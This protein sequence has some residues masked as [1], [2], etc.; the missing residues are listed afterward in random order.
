M[1]RRHRQRVACAR[2]CVACAVG[3]ACDVVGGRRFVGVGV[4]AVHARALGGRFLGLLARGL[5]APRPRTRRL[6]AR[7]G[8][9][10][11]RGQHDLAVLVFSVGLAAAVE[12]VAGRA[13]TLAPAVADVRMAA[14]AIRD[15]YA[16]RDAREHLDGVPPWTASLLGSGVPF[17]GWTRDESRSRWVSPVQSGGE[18]GAWDSRI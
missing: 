7:C 18:A 1:P 15:A 10:C 6:A 2:A 13:Q 11:Q 14:D 17:W 8:E 5:D 3:C 4:G 9:S 16:S 12:A